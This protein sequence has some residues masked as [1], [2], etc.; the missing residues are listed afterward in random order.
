MNVRERLV[1]RAD[2]NVHMGTGHLMRCLALAQAWQAHSGEATF[3]TACDSPR[4][5]QRLR[6]EGFQ[7]VE[8]DTT[9]P[10]P[11]E[12]EAVSRVLAAHPS[13]WVVLDGYHFD[14]ACQRRI[15]EAGHPLLVIDDMAHLDHYYADVV[16]NQNIHAEQL[17]YKCEPETRLLL[18]TRYV[19]LRREFWSWR[20]WERE[21][22]DVA[23]K[24][25]VTLGGGDFDNQTLKV[26]Q[27]LQQMEADILEATVVVG[28]SNP[29][30]QVIEAAAGDAIGISLVRNASHMPE[31]MSWADVAVTAGGSTCWEVAFMGLPNT[32]LTLA[33]NQRGIAEGLDEHG[34]ALSMG[35]H[36]KV[37]QSGLASILQDI[38][39]DRERREEMSEKGRRLVDG[40]G[41]E[42]VIALMNGALNTEGRL[43]VRP[44]HM[45][46]A[47]L[48]W[49]W[50]NDPIVRVN[51]F[52]PD[53]I[54]LEDHIEWYNN[55]L[56]S[57][58]TRFWI[59]ELGQEP[60]AQ[61]RY[62][63]GANSEAEI[64]FSVE[65]AHRGKGIGTKTI[66]LTRELACEELALRR[67]RAV[68]FS[69]NKASQRTFVKS[70]FKHLGQKQ[71]S[72]HMCDVFLWKCPKDKRGA[73]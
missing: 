8:L 23:R 22:P 37:T 45:N 10:V 71:I 6:D 66:M 59:I 7:V 63:R 19:L 72:G 48:L 4:L 31:L 41:F 18:G 56:S 14:S 33:E 55:R 68:V 42:R 26:I 65:R 13:A 28:A 61:I 11:R 34:T 51:S 64:S 32:V 50:A 1:I 53:P 25:L 35:W 52:Q 38:I 2:A 49:R 39:F 21:I 36:S 46:D 62:D 16:L 57:P 73:G 69:S 29:H 44:A 70:G 17:V 43:Q 9:H 5:L 24:V 20:E 40:A 47:Q 3:V 54:P 67:I 12:R 15:K 30:F 27:A 60:V 58:D